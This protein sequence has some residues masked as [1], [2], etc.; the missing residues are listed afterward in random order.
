MKKRLNVDTMNERCKEVAELLKSLAHPQRLMITCHLAEGEKT[1]SELQELCAISQSQLS[2]FLGRLSREGLIS[3]RREG[4]YSYY[5]IKN[6]DIVKLLGSM[7][8]I[9]C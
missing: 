8:K 2:Q 7:Q 1:V 5:K 3:S 4:Q 9:F 6:A